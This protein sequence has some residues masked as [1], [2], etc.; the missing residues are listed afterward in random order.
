[1]YR[2]IV[3]GN[4][5]ELEKITVSAHPFNR[6]WPGKQRDRSQSETAYMVRRFGEGKLDVV[7][8][9]KEEIKAAV[10]RPLSKNIALYTGKH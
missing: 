2:I 3:N 6:T 1:M 5:V 10:I 4:I 8:E 7:I 9:T